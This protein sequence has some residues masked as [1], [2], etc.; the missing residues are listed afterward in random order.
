MQYLFVASGGL[1]IFIIAL[2]LG[3]RRKTASDYILTAWLLLFI[4]NFITLFILNRAS[5]VFSFW[6]RVV[7]EFSDASIFLHGPILWIYTLSL[8]TQNFKPKWTHLYHMVPFTISLPIFLFGILNGPETSLDFR[9]V[10]LVLK[11]LSLLI[12][13]IFVIRRLQAHRYNVE[14]IFSNVEEKYLKWLSFLSWGIL[15]IWGIATASLFVDRMTTV[16]IPQH[17]GL[18]T[19]LAICLFVFLMGYFGVRQA[20]IFTSDLV[21]RSG[22]PD[23]ALGE[24]SGTELPFLKYQKSGLDS[25]GATEIH[26]RLKELMVA[27]KPYL[28][29][30]LTLFSLAAM[31]KVHPNHV[32]QVINSLEGQNFFDYINAHRVE[33]AKEKIRSN[34]TRNLTL[35]GIAYDC[36]F[37]SKASF[38]RAFKKFT[39]QTPTDFMK[40]SLDH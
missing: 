9:N 20:A 6:E 25:I 7:F 12:Y 39:E 37:N 24:E 27:Q 19:N 35:L 8:S 10:L 33:L 38:N 31:L 16:S 2:I 29:K 40:T 34:E 22:G 3:K 32:S 1:A 21:D 13:L 28:E 5:Q 26:G 30:E 11:M 18:L 15:I 17:G 14:N 36:G 4:V 23:V